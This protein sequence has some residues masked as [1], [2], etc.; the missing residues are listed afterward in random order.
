MT[1]HVLRTILGCDVGRLA[2]KKNFVLDRLV[3][4]SFATTIGIY[5]VMYVVSVGLLGIIAK[6]SH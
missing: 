6:A 1:A 2:A 5:A 4:A 3:L